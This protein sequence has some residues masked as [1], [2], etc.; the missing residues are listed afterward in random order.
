M[1]IIRAIVAG[2]RDCQ[3]LAAMRDPRT[4]ASEAT[5]EKA[6]EGDYRTEHLF[7][8]RQSLDAFDPLPKANRGMRPANCTA[9]PKSGNEGRA[10]F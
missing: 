4:H 7:A 3:K 10:G 6:L 9:Y 8:L 1:K 5:I 2:E